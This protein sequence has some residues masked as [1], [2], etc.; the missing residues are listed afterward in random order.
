M[1]IDEKIV[2]RLLSEGESARVEFTESFGK[3]TADKAGEAICSFANDLPDA[4]KPGYFIIGIRDDGSFS[5]P[6]IDE[7]M[8]QSLLSFRDDGRIMPRPIINVEKLRLDGGEL[9]VVEVFPS[10]LPPVRYK[11]KVHVRSGRR[12]WVATAQEERVLS[13]KRVSSART[14]DALPCPDS[15]LGDIDLGAFYMYRSLA[16]DE[17][18]IRENQRS[19]E[20]QMASLRF[21]DLKK[22][23]PTFA[24]II[25]FG[26]NSRYWLPG[27]YIQFVRFD[28]VSL[29]DE[30][31]DQGIVAGSMQNV[32]L[33]LRARI[34]AYNQ[35]KTSRINAL[36]EKLHSDYSE[37]VI[38]ELLLNAIMHRDYE[39]NAPVRFY[40]YNDHIEIQNTGG[41]Y[42]N[43]NARNYTYQNDYRNPVIA[44]ILR[45]LG[46]VNRFGSG[47]SRAITLS[48]QNGNPEPEFEFHS[49]YSKVTIR[50]ASPKVRA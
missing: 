7:Q 17:K 14:F 40:W 2:Q 26:D 8:I 5:N 50:K 45:N 4:K 48:V 16:V 33:E 43:V 12:R 44:E 13:E 29:A 23:C 36:Q 15:T 10:D 27:A 19:L 34:R 25:G 9:L 1:A 35:V 6:V 18:V 37:W 41:L 46:F 21:Y 39:S 42:G 3:N 11:E 47:I 31:V 24:G 38:R 32:V 30:V 49:S 22:R 28:G 20:E